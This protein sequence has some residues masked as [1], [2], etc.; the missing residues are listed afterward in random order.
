MAEQPR[1]KVAIVSPIGEE[2]SEVRAR[3][4]EISDYIV[5]PVAT[6]FEFGIFRSDREATPGPITPKILRALLDAPLVIVDLT[7]H[8]PN[9]FYELC[10]AHSFG[11]PVVLLKDDTSNIPF[12][13]NDERVIALG[14][15]GKIGLGQGE[16]TKE[17]LREAFKAVLR[18]DFQPTSIVTEVANVQNIESMTPQD[19]IASELAAVRRRVDQI[20]H[21]LPRIASQQRVASEGYK[22]ADIKALMELTESLINQGFVSSN[23]LESLVTDTTSPTF[24][25]WANSKTKSLADE[26]SNTSEVDWDDIPF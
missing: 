12:D 25:E 23:E 11:V 4:D 18:D 9:V 19:P 17:K 5:K 6:E 16:K 1:K 10:F 8:N 22:I 24:D 14:D 21:I 3:A 2:G 13:I 7:G 26:S 20:F 15:Q